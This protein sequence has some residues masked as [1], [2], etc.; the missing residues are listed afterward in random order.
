MFPYH[1][2]QYGGAA[3]LVP[4][5]IFVALFGAVGLSGE[6][7]LGRLTGTGPIGAYQH[8]MKTRNKKGGALLGSLPLLG[9]LGIAIGYAI[10]VG[11][12]VRYLAGAVTGSLFSMPSEQYFS[13]ITGAF[14]GVPWHLFVVVATVAALVLGIIQGIETVSK[15]MMPAFFI[16]F[17]MIAV[18]VAFLP[19]AME[20]YRY[21]LVQSGNFC[22]SPSHG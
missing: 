17:F 14:G 18:R 7:A 15:F 1:V 8:V 21:L 12:V 13:S 3:F 16:L 11:W 9:S 22:L 2:G 19:G 5:F 4:Y 20:G 10:I 6:F